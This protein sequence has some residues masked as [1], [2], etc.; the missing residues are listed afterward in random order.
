MEKTFDLTKGEAFNL[1][2]A[3]LSISARNKKAEFLNSQYELIVKLL[4]VKKALQVTM[5]AL[6]EAKVT[7]SQ[8]YSDKELGEYVLPTFTVEEMKIIVGG[9]D[10]LES[11]EK[12]VG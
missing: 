11:F 5:E 9:P 2:N 10:E 12:L 6:E 7:M 3:V 8:L 4:K 1:Y